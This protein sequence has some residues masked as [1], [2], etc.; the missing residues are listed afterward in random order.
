MCISLVYETTKQVLKNS[1]IARK[2]QHWRR[3]KKR[4]LHA[5][6]SDSHSCVNRTC[7]ILSPVS[8]FFFYM[9]KDAP[10]SL[11]FSAY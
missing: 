8:M 6:G 7:H 3:A 9:C 5:R 1:I 4:A 11:I 10:T 2:I